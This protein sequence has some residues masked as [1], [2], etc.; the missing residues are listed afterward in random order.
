MAEAPATDNAAEEPKKKKKLP[1]TMIIVLAVTMIEAVVFFVVFKMV[2]GGPEAAHGED[3]H[4]IEGE[5]AS[6]PVGTAEIQLVKS[7]KVPNDKSGRMYIYDMDVSIVVAT[8]DLELAQGLVDSRAADIADR[9]ARVVR[10]APHQ[11]LWEDD[12]RALRQQ[13]HAG[14]AEI[15]DDEDLVKRI[16]IPRFVPMRSD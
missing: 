8:D 14:L 1:K 11:M 3:S 7:F 5:A 4:V 10:S 12:L 16:L 6:Q 9:L 2:G 15:A 13:V